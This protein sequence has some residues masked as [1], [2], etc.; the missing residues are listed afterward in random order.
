MHNHIGIGHDE[1]SAG[2]GLPPATRDSATTRFGRIVFI[3]LFVI[4]SRL[5]VFLTTAR[6]GLIVAAKHR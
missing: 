1:A 4:V 6:R 5:V 2:H 3:V